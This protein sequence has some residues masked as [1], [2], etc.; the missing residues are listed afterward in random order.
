MK[1]GWA[2][3][4]VWG[5]S[6]NVKPKVGAGNAC[7]VMFQVGLSIYFEFA[8]TSKRSHVT[9]YFRDYRDALQVRSACIKVGVLTVGCAELLMVPASAVY[10]RVSA[11][12]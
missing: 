4:L 6:S 7:T 10:G 1:V 2:Y 11:V 8:L 5:Y 3:L 9:A 12:Y